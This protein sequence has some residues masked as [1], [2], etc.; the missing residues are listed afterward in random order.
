MPHLHQPIRQRVRVA[1][2]EG[3]HAI[4]P[5]T[6]P[7][8][9]SGLSS[10]AGSMWQ[11]AHVLCRL[12]DSCGR[13]ANF[14]HSLVVMTTNLGGGAGRK[15]LAFDL[16]SGGGEEL[17]QERVRA[18]V[19]EEL[20][21]WP[22]LPPSQRRHARLPLWVCGKSVLALVSRFLDHPAGSRN[23]ELLP[24]CSAQPKAACR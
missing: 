3:Y 1:E 23:L 4:L 17:Q 18:A 22:P 13:V 14:K 15:S 8:P 11:S 12:T 10:R 2:T 7:S 6:T 21:V 16:H 9:Q 24:G 5:P 20:K 19:T